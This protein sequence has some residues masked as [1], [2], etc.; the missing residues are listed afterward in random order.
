MRFLQF[1]ISEYSCC[2]LLKTPYRFILFDKVRVCP[3]LLVHQI[4]DVLQKATKEEQRNGTYDLSSVFCLDI[5]YGHTLWPQV[6]LVA[7]ILCT[8][9]PY[10]E[11]LSF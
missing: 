1:E 11:T 5:H 7:S 9:L 3:V 6:A 8:C 2:V 10:I 4:L